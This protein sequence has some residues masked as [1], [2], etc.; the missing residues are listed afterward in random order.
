MAVRAGIARRRSKG[1]L[2]GPR[3]Y[4][5]VWRRDL[6]DE[7]ELVPDPEQARVVRRIYSEFLSG[8]PQLQI[9][10][11]LNAA[12]IRTSRGGRWG[13]EAVRAILMNPTYAGLIRV[14][15]ELIE[16]RHRQ[17]VPR[18]RWKKAQEIRAVRTTVRQ[19]GRTPFGPHLFRKGLLRCGA[20][21]ASFVPRSE[22][23]RD[24]SVYEVYRCHGRLRDPAFCSVP[25]QRRYLSLSE[26]GGGRRAAD[27]AYLP[28]SGRD[29]SPVRR[30]LSYWSCWLDRRGAV[31]PV[32][33]IPARSY[34]LRAGR[35][36]R[37]V[38]TST[39]S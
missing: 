22:R 9:A 35:F 20:C 5:Y 15:G 1:R 7:R 11:N 37:A 16:A 27:A 25:P 18:R 6:D 26:R 31:L 13:A 2:H 33:V 24:G 8:R 17:I 29:S 32:R 3:P 10:R 23:N 14:D 12:R 4:G 28:A 21:G 34:S 36:S 38:Q 39:R 30:R 19:R